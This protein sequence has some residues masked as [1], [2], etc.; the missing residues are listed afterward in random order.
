MK[1]KVCRPQL[2]FSLHS[3]HASWSVSQ[4]VGSR[5]VVE[6]AVVGRMADDVVNERVGPDGA[7]VVVAAAGSRLIA[8]S[9]LDTCVVGV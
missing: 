5:E 6:G 7:A 9:A 3:M 4:Y 1:L 2:T 8:I